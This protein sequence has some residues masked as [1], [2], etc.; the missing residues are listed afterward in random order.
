MPG[1]RGRDREKDEEERDKGPGD[2]E[3]VEQK[4]YEAAADAGDGELQRDLFGGLDAKLIGKAYAGEA[5]LVEA[6]RR[7]ARAVKGG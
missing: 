4:R 1:T 5:G 3:L 2:D 7:D 6:G